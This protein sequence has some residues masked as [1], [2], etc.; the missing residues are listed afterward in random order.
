MDILLSNSRWMWPIT[1]ALMCVISYFADHLDVMHHPEWI[2]VILSGQHMH[3]THYIL[4]QIIYIDP[5]EVSDWRQISEYWLYHHW[6][7]PEIMKIY[8]DPQLGFSKPNIFVWRAFSLTNR[9]TWIDVN[10]TDI[11][12]GVVRVL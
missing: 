9:C 5:L 1:P 3:N 12:Q 8:I 11:F 6:Y 4:S 2:L 10:S 7:E